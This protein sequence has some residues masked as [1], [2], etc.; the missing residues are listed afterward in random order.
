[1]PLAFILLLVLGCV[2]VLVYKKLMKS[3]RF[4]KFCKDL[5]SDEAVNNSSKMKIKDITNTEKDLSKKVEQ[6][7]KETEKL[8][9]DTDGIKEFLGDRGV[10]DAEKKKEGS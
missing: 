4:D 8:K 6:N 1:M 10:N 5:S 9:Q 2:A 3:P 7:V